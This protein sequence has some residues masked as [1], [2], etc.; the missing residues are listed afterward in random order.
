MFCENPKGNTFSIYVDP[1]EKLGYISCF[2]CQETMQEAFVKW[3][4]TL[5]YGRALYLK[6]AEIV[7][8]RTSGEI[9]TGWKINK[10]PS[11]KWSSH[12]DKEIVYCYNEDKQLTRWCPL[13]DILELNPK[14]KIWKN[15][16]VN[17]CVNMGDD[18]PRQYCCKTHCPNEA[19]EFKE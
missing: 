7:I 4:T 15:L 12:L 5:V 16:C 8:R 14:R 10:S 6:D 11:V 2:S 1:I 3:N 18:N 17:C 9:E 13:D 19:D